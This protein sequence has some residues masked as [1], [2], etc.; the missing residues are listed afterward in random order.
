MT[1]HIICTHF[2]ITKIKKYK[3]STLDI[4]LHLLLMHN[5]EIWPAEQRSL[6]DCCYCL[7]Q[8]ISL[9]HIVVPTLHPS[10]SDT[11]PTIF[12]L[13]KK[14]LSHRTTVHFTTLHAQTDL[15]TF[16]IKQTSSAMFK[17]ESSK[18]LKQIPA[19]IL[20]NHFNQSKFPQITSPKSI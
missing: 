18:L 10:P 2:Y 1:A 13:N 6:M 14:V 8:Q 16:M 12:H 19:I 9:V 17:P 5:P 20:S 3:I 11:T 4:Q 7:F 15:K